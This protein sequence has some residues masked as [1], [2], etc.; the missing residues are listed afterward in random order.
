MSLRLGFTRKDWRARAAWGLVKQCF[1]VRS[2]SQ[3][4]ACV[5]L[6]SDLG[7]NP[8]IAVP[9]PGPQVP[10]VPVPAPP[11]RL[12]AHVRDEPA[13]PVLRGERHRVENQARPS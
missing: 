10:G 6:Y 4:D 8:R 11:A 2:D 7:G 3:T 12:Q 1:D 13:G 9:E 5:R